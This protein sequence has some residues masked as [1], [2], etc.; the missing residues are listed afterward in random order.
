MTEKY[1]IVWYWRAWR[2]FRRGQWP[3]ETE[4]PVYRWFLRIGPLEIRRWAL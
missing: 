2:I 4:Y 1:Q 3:T